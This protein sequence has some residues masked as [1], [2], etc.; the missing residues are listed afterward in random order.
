[1][2]ATGEHVFLVPG[3]S[4]RDGERGARKELVE[5]E[6]ERRELVV[7]VLV[8]GSSGYVGI[9]DTVYRKISTRISEKTRL[10]PPL[11]SPLSPF[12]LPPSP[13]GKSLEDNLRK[14]KDPFR[15][16][17]SRKYERWYHRINVLGLRNRTTGKNFG[18]GPGPLPLSLYPYPF[19]RCL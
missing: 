1:M 6:Q 9:R 14:Y 4:L 5:E 11:A 10:Y 13:E 12:P 18:V 8:D 7:V 19:S 15:E 16:N 3:G 17:E 2:Y